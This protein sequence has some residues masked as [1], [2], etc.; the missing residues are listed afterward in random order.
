MRP[1][2][3]SIVRLIFSSITLEAPPVSIVD[4]A[5]EIIIAQGWEISAGIA[6]EKSELWKQEI[7]TRLQNELNSLHEMGR[8]PTF[9]FNSS[10]GYMLQGACFREPHDDDELV[11][12][13][14]RRA[15]SSLYSDFLKQVS[16]E[17]F[18]VLCGRLLEL[19]G[20]RD[21]VVTRR[22]A[23]E[24]IDFYGKLELA[25]FLPVGLTLTLQRHLSTILIGQAKRYLDTQAG[26][27]EIRDL[28]GA[29]SLLRAN[30]VGSVKYPFKNLRI[31]AVEPLFAILATTGS[32]SINAWRLLRESGVIG[33]DGEMIAAFLADQG[34]C[35]QDSQLDVQAFNSW[36]TI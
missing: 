22:S 35:V 13:K 5:A 17:Q 7:A 29:I 16:P 11:A 25:D 1:G 23:D 14:Q 24:G 18:E 12:H 4:I 28:V 6:R 15:R 9:V 33:F 21:A 19:M 2:P 27:A 10:S 26:T 32:L 31:R 34:I 36:L 3:A 30:A 20:V 8:P